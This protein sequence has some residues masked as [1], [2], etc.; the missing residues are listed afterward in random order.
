MV[1]SFY[2]INC[3]LNIE[4]FEYKTANETTN[5]YDNHDNTMS[6][7]ELIGYSVL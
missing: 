4:K 6:K 2:Q 1:Y 7:L 3:L 5:I